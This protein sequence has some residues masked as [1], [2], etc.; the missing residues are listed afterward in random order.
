MFFGAILE[1]LMRVSWK[2]S[3]QSLG[4]I[5]E[6][7][8][9]TR[10]KSPMRY[11]FTTLVVPLTANLVVGHDTMRDANSSRLGIVQRANGGAGIDKDCQIIRRI[12]FV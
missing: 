5:N 12:A 9:Q 6:E 11:T 1:I 10:I 2:G 4:L 7:M 3:S 8:R